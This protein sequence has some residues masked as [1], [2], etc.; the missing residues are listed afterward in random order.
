MSQFIPIYRIQGASSQSS[1]VDQHVRVRGVVTA[2]LRKGFYVQ[3]PLSNN[4][5]DEAKGCSHAVF[6]FSRRTRP[7]IGTLVEI[8]AEVIEYQREENDK[9]MTQLRPTSIEEQTAQAS[10]SIAA[11]TLSAG[12]MP[13]KGDEL[14]V[15]LNSLEGMLVRM[16][17]GA[18]FIQPS[19]PFGDYVVSLADTAQL[20]PA[21]ETHRALSKGLV[22]DHQ[23]FERWLPSFRVPVDVAPKLNVGAILLSDIQGPL[24]YRSGAYQMAVSR[25]FE[26]EDYPVVPSVS[27]LKPADNSIRILTL[28]CFNL[29]PHIEAAARV[30]N[31]RKDIDDD[32]GNGQFS[33]LALAIV[34]QAHCPDVIALQEIQDNDGAELTDTVDASS[35]YA[36]LINAIIQQGGERYDWVDIP[37]ENGADGGQPGGNIRNGFLYLRDK[38]HL[39][40]SS[41]IR[42]GEDDIAFE[43]S[44][45]PIIAEFCLANNRQAS[46]VVANV[47]LASKRRQ[48]SIF[49]P[50]RPGYDPKHSIRVQQAQ[51][52]KAYTDKLLQQN[53]YYYITGDFNDLQSSPT[54]LALEGNNNKNLLNTLEQN[55]RYDYNHRGKLHALMHG[56]VP[57]HIWENGLATYE[58]LHGN[59]LTGVWPGQ[60]GSKAS[61]HAY[62]IAEL[63]F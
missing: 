45:K 52:I 54:L 59:E 39:V 56:I 9:P 14:R 6:V 30:D 47:H 18:T 43:D 2:H 53:K 12:D 32:K 60:L 41:V 1:Y 3:D 42:L 19:N 61:D 38:I 49:S 13:A 57:K 16:A 51:L 37:P 8:D 29:D 4:P 46:V 50:N 34:N 33:K 25:E 48:H 7:A 11:I 35:T 26:F 15:Y 22:F 58:T 20:D 62:V 5:P 55:Q 17:A 10:D 31:P 63:T 23:D 27:Q 44:R 28:N 40:A 36:E 24:H 21:L